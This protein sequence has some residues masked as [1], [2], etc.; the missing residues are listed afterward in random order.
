MFLL[1]GLGCIL[2]KFRIVSHSLR[3]HTGHYC[4]PTF[5]RNEHY[6]LYCGSQDIEDVYH[7]VCICPRLTNIRK[8]YMNP[9]YYNR[10]SVFKYNK[11]W[12]STDVTILLNLAKYL[13][14][15]IHVRK[16]LL[17]NLLNGTLKFALLLPLHDVKISKH[18]MFSL[19]IFFILKC[20]IFIPL[21]VSMKKYS[22][23]SNIIDFSCRIALNISLIKISLIN[24][25]RSSAI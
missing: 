7:F 15:A 16:V 24:M 4:W 10:P 11:L 25:Y 19:F 18:F 12:S 8:R 13:K 9:Y 14:F 3:V 17:C 21:T 20:L 23:F 2:T 6:C 1:Y 22:K 5:A